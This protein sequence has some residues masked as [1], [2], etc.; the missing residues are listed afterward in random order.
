M[1]SLR[2]WPLV[3]TVLAASSSCATADDVDG[4]N[5]FRKPD[6][7]AADTESPEV[8]EADSGVP[9]AAI[10]PDTGALA[11]MDADAGD[12][13]A[14]AASVANLSLG[15]YHTCA[16]MTDGTVRCWGYNFYGQVGDG[17]TTSPVGAPIT[18]GSIAN[19]LRTSGGGNHTCARLTG[20]LARCWGSNANGQIGDGSAVNRPTPTAPDSLTGVVEIAAG[21]NH[22]CARLTDATL[23][24]W[25]NNAN[26]QLGI[27]TLIDRSVP[28]NVSVTSVAQVELGTSHTCI[29]TS[30]GSVRCWGDNANGQLGNGSTVDSASPVTVPSL[31]SVSM[32][33]VGGYHTCAIV[34]TGATSTVRCWGHNT[35]GQLGD[36]STTAR[37]A[38]VNVTGLVG[39]SELAAG[40]YH[41]CARLS[42]NT[43]RCWGYNANGQLG[44]GSITNR[45]TPVTVSGLSNVSDID[46][47]RAH[48]CAKKTDGTMWC[49]G[50]NS[51]GQLG[52]GTKTQSAT[53][54]QVVF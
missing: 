24:C 10:D 34:G 3:L 8:T 50:A 15:A 54:V 16:R 52:D 5:T 33:A 44:D 4:G 18:V 1:S 37:S 42:D 7:I 48:T 35:Y 43:V 2:A 45:S 12:D 22:T 31:T 38:P 41:T 36:G 32:I 14:P 20:D 19:A 53:P 26:G 39:V 30:S 21:Q 17:T 49:W 47:G 46:L 13:A 29:R 9:D 6:A 51:Y 25:G 28:T 23:R 40:V 27:G 11:P